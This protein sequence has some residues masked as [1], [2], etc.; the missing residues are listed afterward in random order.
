MFSSTNELVIPMSRLKLVGIFLGAVA[1]VALG[2]L[3]MIIE[4]R[5]GLFGKFMG[6]VATVFFGAVAVSVLYRM[7]NPEPAVII[8]AHGIVDNSS[9]TSIGF[10]AWDEIAEVSEYTFQNQT[11]LGIMPKDL[12]RLLARMPKW[13]RAAIR[14][15]L[16]LGAAPI[17][18]PQVVLGVKVSDLVREINVRFRPDDGKARD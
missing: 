14:A 12:D 1:F 11:F 18:I 9:G 17:N 15:N 3:L 8:N 13:K 10:I 5:R 16:G 6:L 7:L 4:T 2:V